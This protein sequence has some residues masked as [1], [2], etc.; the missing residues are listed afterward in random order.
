MVQKGF[1]KSFLETRLILFNHNSITKNQIASSAGSN[2]SPLQFGM[3]A[4]VIN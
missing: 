4:N 3:A 2:I 1:L